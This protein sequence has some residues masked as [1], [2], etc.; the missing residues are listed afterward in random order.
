MNFL[1]FNVLNYAICDSLLEHM[2]HKAEFK[3]CSDRTEVPN[4]FLNLNY[5][6]LQT[7]LGPS[8][9]RALDP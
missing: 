1:H 6:L 9:T 2:S 3:T 5:L 8:L 4:P 7:L